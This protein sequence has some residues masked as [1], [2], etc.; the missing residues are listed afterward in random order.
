MRPFAEEELPQEICQLPLP[1]P[2]LPDHPLG[3]TDHV[4]TAERTESLVKFHALTT[5]MLMMIS[6][7]NA[8]RIL[9]EELS[10]KTQ[11]MKRNTAES[12]EE[13]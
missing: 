3:G 13:K 10:A 12:S 4:F 6:T 2:E 11:T 9:K 5:T 1:L 8:E 7:F